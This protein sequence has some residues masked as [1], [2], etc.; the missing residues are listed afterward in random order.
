M[1]LSYS[2]KWVNTVHTLLNKYWWQRMLPHKFDHIYLDALTLPYVHITVSTSMQSTQPSLIL[3]LRPEK[4]HSAVCAIAITLQHSCTWTWEQ[5][6]QDCRQSPYR[7]SSEPHLASR[8]V[9]STSSCTS[10][11]N[12]FPMLLADIWAASVGVAVRRANVPI[13]SCQKAI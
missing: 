13:N 10:I 5:A 4:P 6:F 3:T 1:T 8:G 9:V 11:T 2:A 7:I 12:A